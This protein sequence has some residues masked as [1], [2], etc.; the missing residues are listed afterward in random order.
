MVR[1][2]EN[3]E[4]RIEAD[5]ALD[6]QTLDLADLHRRHEGAI[7]ARAGGARRRARAWSRSPAGEWSGDL[8]YHRDA[9]RQRS[10]ADAS[11]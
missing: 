6:A 11:R 2:G 3:D 9:Q 4:A 5:Y 7:A 1:G 10:G 8:H